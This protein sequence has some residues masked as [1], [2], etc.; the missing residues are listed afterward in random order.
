M[1]THMHTQAHA[2]MHSETCLLNIPGILVCQ[3]GCILE[4]LDNYLAERGLMMPLDL[5]AK[6]R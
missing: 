5:G 1:Q 3:A 4:V 6:G 2:W